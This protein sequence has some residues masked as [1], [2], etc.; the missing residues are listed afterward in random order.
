MFRT[1]FIFVIYFI[2]CGGP[3]SEIAPALQSKTYSDLL[4]EYTSCSGKG[5]ID[6]YG[7]IRGSM[8][9]LYMSKKDSTFF[10]FKDY[11][12]RKTLLIWITPES[13]SARNLIENKQYTYDMILDLFPFLHVLESNDVTKFL[14]G[15]QPDYLQKFNYVE[16]SDSVN[17]ALEFSY[18]HLETDNHSLL[19]AK[20]HDG[21][22]NQTVTIQIKKRI[23]NQSHIDLKKYWNIQ[24]S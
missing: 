23:W 7:P 1:N 11:L 6:A 19:K 4:D 3:V 10:Q 12:G 9:F 2:G 13:V 22:S 17:I 20:F 8:S 24:H 5:K 18:G 21:K 16:R 15:I 14:W